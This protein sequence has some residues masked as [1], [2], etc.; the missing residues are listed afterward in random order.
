MLGAPVD[1]LSVS[2]CPQNRLIYPRSLVS[3]ASIY[4]WDSFQPWNLFYNL[5]AELASSSC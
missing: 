4:F 1:S 3:A 2:Y 5:R